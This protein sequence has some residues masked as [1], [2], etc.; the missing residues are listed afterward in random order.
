MRKLKKILLITLI[1]ILLL[2]GS[3]L[4]IIGPWPVYKNTDFKSAKYYQKTLTE[5][6]NASKNIHLSETPEPLKAGW[7]SQIITP[8]IGT[9]L[10]G[11]SDR[12]GK[13]STG[14]HDELYAKAIALNDGEDTVVIVGTDLLLVP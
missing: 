12:K 2:V 3:F 14:V 6:K 5:L 4:L 13:P 7:A 11:Y 1:V 9:P 8:P 10:G